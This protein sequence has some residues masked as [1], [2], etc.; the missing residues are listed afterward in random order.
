[1]NLFKCIPYESKVKTGAIIAAVSAIYSIYATRKEIVDAEFVEVPAPLPSDFKKLSDKKKKNKDKDKDKDKKKKKK[2]KDKK[3]NKKDKENKK[4][5]VYKY[6][7]VDDDINLV[8]QDE[9]EDYEEDKQVKRKKSKSSKDSESFDDLVSNIHDIINSKDNNSMKYDE[10]EDDDEDED[11]EEVIDEDEDEEDESE[12]DIYASNAKDLLGRILKDMDAVEKRIS[13]K[14]EGTDD[15]D[16]IY[17]VF[18][19]LY[20]EIY[21]TTNL[22]ITEIET[23][24]MTELH[25]TYSKL[26]NLF[27]WYCKFV[28]SYITEGDPHKYLDNAIR[29]LRGL[30]DIDI[31]ME[32][33]SPVSDEISY[34]DIAKL[35]TPEVVDSDA[36]DTDEDDEEAVGMLPKSIAENIKDN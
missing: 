23:V 34:D 10:D 7:P 25:K 1:M 8:Y 31:A 16:D 2:D 12:E 26:E 17:F 22:F 33:Y 3:K 21:N 19:G 6:D 28:A 32:K 27:T 20:K 11:Y 14:Y 35:F 24:N 29:T 5:K 13:D 4:K 30:K 15:Y 18:A 9:D 36:D